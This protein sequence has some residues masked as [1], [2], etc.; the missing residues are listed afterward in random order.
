LNEVRF[1]SKEFE[2]RTPNKLQSIDAATNKKHTAVGSSDG[3]RR[4]SSTKL[5]E[6]SYKSTAADP[7]QETQNWTKFNY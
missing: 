7:E 2:K 1:L 6:R 3:G 4:E 5:G